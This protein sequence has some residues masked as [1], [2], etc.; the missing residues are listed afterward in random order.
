MPGMG[1]QALVAEGVRDP[2]GLLCQGGGES[3]CVLADEL[4][5]GTHQWVCLILECVEGSHSVVFFF[6]FSPGGGG[7]E[8][9]LGSV[10]VGEGSHMFWCSA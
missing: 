7:E 5:S 2:A 1:G 9:H 10:Q 8:H 4:R 3:G 6:F